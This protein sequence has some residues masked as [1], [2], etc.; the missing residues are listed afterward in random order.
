MPSA[1]AP[2]PSAP[3]AGGGSPIMHQSTLT[4]NPLALINGVASDCRFDLPMSEEAQSA[5]AALRNKEASLWVFGHPE[6]EAS[7]REVIRSG[8][9]CLE[10]QPPNLVAAR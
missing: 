6:V 10:A 8:Y 2:V 1:V 3:P 7:W 9:R 4:N 5:A